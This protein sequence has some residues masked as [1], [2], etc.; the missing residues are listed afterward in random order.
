[1]ARKQQG[2][3]NQA[4]LTIETGD[5]LRI[6]AHLIAQKHLKTVTMGCIGL[7]PQGEEHCDEREKPRILP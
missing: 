6:L 7:P 4:M 5:A 1:M 3:Y 2:K